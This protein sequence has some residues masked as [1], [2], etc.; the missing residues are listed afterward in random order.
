MLAPIGYYYEPKHDSER[1]HGEQPVFP[2]EEGGVHNEGQRHSLRVSAC[3]VI[4]EGRRPAARPYCVSPSM[5]RGEGRY[6]H[7][8]GEE[9]GTHALSGKGIGESE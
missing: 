8:S 7:A 3:H 4:S 5:T 2:G 6:H 1:G 9:D